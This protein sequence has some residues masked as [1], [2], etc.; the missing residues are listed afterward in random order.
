MKYRKLGKTGLKVSVV[1]MGAWQCGGE[2]GKEFTQDEVTAIL[3]RGKELGINL[4]DT[5]E[6]YGDHVSERLIGGAI[7]RERQD[8]IIATKFGHKYHGYLNRTEP[9]TPRDV[10]QQLDESLRSLRT[11]YIDIYQYH[12]WGDQQFDDSAV[13]DV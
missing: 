1:G 12:S 5:A 3:N 9:R 10:L 13:L 7:E 11:D 2:W 4:I 8:W 6:C